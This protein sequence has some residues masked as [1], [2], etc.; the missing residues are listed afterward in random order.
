MII[1]AEY[2]KHFVLCLLIKENNCII[3]Y[4]GKDIS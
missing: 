2:N 1:I 4:H 3:V